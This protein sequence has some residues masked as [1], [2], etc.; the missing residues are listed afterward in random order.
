MGNIKNFFLA[1]IKNFS[2]KYNF[3]SG[4]YIKN[5]WIYQ[6]RV[7][8]YRKSKGIQRPQDISTEELLNT[9]SRYDSKR[10]VKSIR[11][12]LTRIGLEKISKIQN[13]SKN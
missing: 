9:L 8:Y 2:H 10:K 4:V 6:K 12:K 3:F 1:N 13:I 11:R 7:R 5:G